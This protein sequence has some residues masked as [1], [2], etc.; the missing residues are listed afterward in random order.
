MTGGRLT[1]HGGDVQ[2]ENWRYEEV[3][4][5]EV[6]A[7]D[8]EEPQFVRELEEERADGRTSV[9]RRIGEQRALNCGVIND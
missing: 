6:S 5:G 2:S 7:F 8:F 1:I 9:E 4:S 3:A